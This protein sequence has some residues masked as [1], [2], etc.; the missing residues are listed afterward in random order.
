[1]PKRRSLV[2]TAR[3]AIGDTPARPPGST[4][5]AAEAPAKRSRKPAPK[6]QKE[7]PPPA[8]S[9]APERSEPA[10]KP[11]AATLEPPPADTARPTTPYEAMAQFAA[12]TLRQNL[13]TGARLARCKS[14]MEVF[15]AQTAHA[16]A[17]AQSFFAVSLRLMQVSP[18][19]RSWTSIR[20]TGSRVV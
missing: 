17:L 11:L 14:P 4:A 5:A 13:E 6:A 12:A 9:R 20:N 3:E 8:F 16:A 2:G 1:M 10:P 7:P 19:A 18:Y 15:A